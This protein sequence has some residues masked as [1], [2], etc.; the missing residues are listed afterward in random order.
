MADFQEAALQPDDIFAVNLHLLQFEPTRNLNKAPRFHTSL[1]PRGFKRQLSKLHTAAHHS[2]LHPQR[3][4]PIPRNS[5]LLDPPNDG[6]RFG[7][8]IRRIRAGQPHHL[9]ATRMRRLNSRRCI[10]DHQTLLGPES[11]QPR[12]FQI[13][14]GMRLSLHHVVRPDQNLRNRQPA[15]SQTR[16]ARS[17]VPDVTTPQRPS[18]IELNKSAAPGIAPTPR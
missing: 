3:P 15:K 7:Q 17:R 10:F 4:R 12:P 9:H 8:S 2:N 11:Q 5:K 6:V 14:L 18:G 1:D 13:R 16:V